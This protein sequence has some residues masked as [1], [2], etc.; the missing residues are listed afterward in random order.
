MYLYLY[1]RTVLAVTSSYIFRGASEQAS[2]QARNRN[3]TY[4]VRLTE[5]FLTS[6][7]TYITYSILLRA[8][9]KTQSTV[10]EHTILI[11]NLI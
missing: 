4:L 9:Y 10:Y 6:N 1:I 11:G 5:L 3:S 2:K 7:L 8:D